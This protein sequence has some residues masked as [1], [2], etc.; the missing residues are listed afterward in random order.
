MSLLINELAFAD[1]EDV[2]PVVGLLHRPVVG[3]FHL[4]LDRDYQLFHC[5]SPPVADGRTVSPQARRTAPS[6][7]LRRL[8]QARAGT[9]A[10]MKLPLCRGRPNALASRWAA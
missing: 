6:R 8:I 9:G 4:Q 2:D 10:R 7:P 5:G 3:N 1:P